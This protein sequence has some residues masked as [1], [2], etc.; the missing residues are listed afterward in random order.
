MPSLRSTRSPEVLIP[1][2]A[3]INLRVQLRDEWHGTVVIEYI[4]LA[5]TQLLV[6]LHPLDDITWLV[7]DNQTHGDIGSCLSPVIRKV[8]GQ[9]ETAS[10]SYSQYP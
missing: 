3:S 6:V 2:E 1:H 10:H 8:P 7:F 4:E 5:D 9:R